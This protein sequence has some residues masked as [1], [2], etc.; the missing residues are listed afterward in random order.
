MVL[1]VAAAIS[2]AVPFEQHCW[3]TMD[4]ATLIFT[5]SLAENLD[6]APQLA[7][8][9]YGVPDVNKWSF[10]ARSLWPVGI[11]SHATHGNPETSARF[12]ELLRPRGIRYEMRFSFASDGECW[13]SGGF[14]R[15]GGHDFDEQ[16]AALLGSMASDIADG[17]RR[18]VLLADAFGDAPTTPGL[19]LF[20][21]HGEV[22]AVS[23]AAAEY[24]YDL[25][26]DYH[27]VPASHLPHAIR[28]VAEL[29]RRAGAEGEPAERTAR[30]RAHT[31][32]GRWLLLYGTRIG[33]PESARIAVIIE[34]AHPAELAPIIVAAY[35]LSERER[36]V[37]QLCMHG[38]STNEIA[39]RL[40]ISPL[41]VQDHLKA[42]F[43][44]IGVRSRRE[45]VATIAG[46]QFEPRI[47]P[48]P[49]DGPNRLGFN[50]DLTRSL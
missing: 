26:D 25:F 20:D 46:E 11:L 14:Y 28:A 4:P 42:I 40:H 24:A 32:S 49:P 30:A 33:G 48:T 44:K 5:G 10:L 9:E 47:Q 7:T 3:H 16:E 12:R 17:F 13:G 2:K 22:E 29:A 37:T 15:D 35:G 43:S 39:Q 21:E 36:Q 45:L 19:V 23:E 27:G 1:Q 41:T 18:A 34:Q 38:L 8:L 6:E 50:I 31:R